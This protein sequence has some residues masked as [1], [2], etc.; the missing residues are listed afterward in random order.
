MVLALD[1]A[2]IVKDPPD[3]C[4]YSL[5]QAV[6]IE[7]PAGDYLRWLGGHHN[8]GKTHAHRHAA[9]AA[10][11]ES[12]V[13]RLGDSDRN[14]Y[15]RYLALT[16]DLIPGRFRKA[17]AL[18]DEVLEALWVYERKSQRSIFDC[19]G[20]HHHDG[21]TRKNRCLRRNPRVG[22]RS[23]QLNACSAHLGIEADPLRYKP[24]PAKGRREI[25]T[26]TRGI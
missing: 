13:A 11:P 23:P 17:T 5:R 20:P 2:G 1:R 21:T 19:N 16:I 14:R 4:H 25:V 9:A 8:G 24:R 12:L 18:T 6:P 10:P 26:K 22:I 15:L 3:R 7:L